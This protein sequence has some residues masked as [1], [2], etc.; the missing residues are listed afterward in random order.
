MTDWR[1][2]TQSILSSLDIRATKSKGQN[3]IIK[4]SVI[5]RIIEAANI[6][7]TSIDRDRI[8]EIGGGVGILTEALV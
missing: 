1:Q 2:H 3:F 8:I 6:N 4:P 7:T 5:R